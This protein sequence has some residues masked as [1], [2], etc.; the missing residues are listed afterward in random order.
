MSDLIPVT[1][2]EFVASRNTA[3]RLRIRPGKPYFVASCSLPAMSV[4]RNRYLAIKYLSA[5][6]QIDMSRLVVLLQ[7]TSG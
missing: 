7:E 1:I 5:R 3:K 6:N 4:A 2:M